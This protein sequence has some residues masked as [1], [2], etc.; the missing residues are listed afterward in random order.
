MGEGGPRAPCVLDIAP[1]QLR[2]ADISIGLQVIRRFE[3]RNLDDGVC[4]LTR[5]G[6]GPETDPSFTM[7][8]GPV[9]SR[10]L[11][12]D[13]ALTIQID[14]VPDAVADQQGTVEISEASGVV[15]RVE[16]SAMGTDPVYYLLLVPNEL[17]FGRVLVGSEP[18]GRT[19]QIY[20]VQSFPAVIESIR[21]TPPEGA[22]ALIGE[23]TSPIATPPGASFEF[24]IRFQPE[25]PG[26]YMGGFEVLGT[27]DVAA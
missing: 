13:T 4:W 20:N 5:V 10:V 7:P 18:R 16:L 26:Q 19:I 8:D 2:F 23:P 12:R 3:V 24:A 17:N 15:H 27:M 25:G 22:F 9:G 14:F 6:L 21:A 1:S 11:L